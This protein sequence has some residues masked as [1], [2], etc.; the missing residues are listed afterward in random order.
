MRLRKLWDGNRNLG[1]IILTYIFMQIV[2]KLY[3]K[4][5]NKIIEDARSEI[6]KMRSNKRNK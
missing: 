6:D 2:T 1:K 4:K 3:K 5:M